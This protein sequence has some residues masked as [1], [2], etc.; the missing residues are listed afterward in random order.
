MVDWKENAARAKKFLEAKNYRKAKKEV[1]L[2]LQK[3]PNQV[4]LLLV[5]YNIYVALRDRDKCLE[6]AELLI[7]HHPGRWIGYGHAAK[8]LAGLKRFREAQERIESGLEKN[9]NHSKLLAI[10]ADIYCSSGNKEKSLEYAQKVKEK[11]HHLPRPIFES[12]LIYAAKMAKDDKSNNNHGDQKNIEAAIDYYFNAKHILSKDN[13]PFNFIF[14]PKNACTSIKASLLHAFANL[15]INNV[16][17]RTHALADSHL[18]ES[19]DYNKQ[20]VALVRNPYSRFISAFADKCRP[21]GDMVA[22]KALCNRYGFDIGKPI[23]MVQLL[24]A[25]ISDEPN[26]I[27]PHFRP[28]SNIL[29]ASA[30]SP[31]RLFFM[32]RFSEFSSFLREQGIELLKRAPHATKARAPKPHEL[33]DDIISKIIHL[34]VN[35]FSLYQYSVDPA[36]MLSARSPRISEF[37]ISPERDLA[38]SASVCCD[39][40]LFSKPFLASTSSIVCLCNHARR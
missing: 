9:P 3:L 27:N 21:E 17:R 33:D 26:M 40:L 13:M 28:Q 34:Y 2:G 4:D 14:V 38:P 39:N 5:A 22:W 37:L 29:C 32:E 11:G 20:F 1:Q 23:S 8:Q 35:D 36:I 25:L 15:D 16:R 12:L 19:I 7:A 30:I 10:A 31:C 18:K 24:D 6:Y